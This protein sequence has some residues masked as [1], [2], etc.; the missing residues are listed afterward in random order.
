MYY[1]R[2]HRPSLYPQCKALMVTKD[3]SF[4]LYPCSRRQQKCQQLSSNSLF[5][6]MCL[7]TSTEL[8]YLSSLLTNPLLSPYFL[9]SSLPSPYFLHSSLP[10]PYSLHSS[11]P[12]P[13]F[14]KSIF[15]SHL[16]PANFTTCE[17]ILSSY[18][19]LSFS[20]PSL[21]PTP[22]PFFFFFFLFFCVQTPQPVV[23]QHYMNR[24]AMGNW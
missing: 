21:L 1:L 24:V 15:L 10:S 2:P 9:H 12:S 13:Y 16:L 8:F 20:S 17:T 4:P 11:L 5:V 23:S 18:S 7:H 14:L 3:P 19:R 6:P 22:Q